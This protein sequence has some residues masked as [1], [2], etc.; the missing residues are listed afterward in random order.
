MSEKQK[1]GRPPSGRKTV[2]QIGLDDDDYAWLEK[3]AEIEGETISSVGRRLL[4][5]AIE[6]AKKRS[7]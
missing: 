4:A 6:K 1:R 3:L 7:R 2:V 5:D